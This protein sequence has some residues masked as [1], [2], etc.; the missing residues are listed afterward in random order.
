MSR[1]PK[2]YVSLKRWTPKSAA[3]AAR[4]RVSKIEVL[5]DEIGGLYGDVDQT[6]VDQCDDM[7][8]CLRGE[9]SLDEAIQVALDEGR[10]L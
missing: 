3:A 6:V 10:S 1:R 9:D 8:R 4:R 7:K 5:L 2:G